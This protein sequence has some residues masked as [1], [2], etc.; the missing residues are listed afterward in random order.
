MWGLGAQGPRKE[1]SLP[2]SKVG[3]TF[4]LLLVTQRSEKNK[5]V[6]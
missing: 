3:I 6:G 2:V 5:T 1:L 4:S